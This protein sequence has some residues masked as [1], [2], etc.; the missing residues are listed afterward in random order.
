MTA[1]RCVRV[2]RFDRLRLFHLADL[3]DNNA[4]PEQPLRGLMGSRNGI[5][6]TAETDL[7]TCFVR[8]R[9]AIKYAT[10][11]LSSAASDW[12]DK[13]EEMLCDAIQEGVGYKALGAFYRSCMA[14]VSAPVLRYAGGSGR[15]ATA[16]FDMAFLT[17][18][19]DARDKFKDAYYRRA[20]APRRRDEGDRADARDKR[21]RTDTGGES[22]SAGDSGDSGSESG[23]ASEDGSDGKSDSGSDLGGSSAD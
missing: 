16:T 7:R 1:L 6:A 15:R 14:K 4:T 23:S 13:L 12:I 20:R 21:Q 8:L 2:G 19:S 10:P 9:R 22:D 18:T 17:G 3:D 11:D 5:S